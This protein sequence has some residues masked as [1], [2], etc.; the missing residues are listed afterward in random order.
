MSCYFYFLCGSNTSRGISNRNSHC[1]FLQKRWN[2]NDCYQPLENMHVSAPPMFF[3]SPSWVFRN[4]QGLLTN[5][6]C[7]PDVSMFWCYNIKLYF[8]LLTKIT[9][10]DNVLLC[11]N[12]IKHNCFI[13]GFTGILCLSG[14]KKKKKRNFSKGKINLI[15]RWCYSY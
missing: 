4:P 2:R 12:F 14:K 5:P 11:F 3:V 9:Y 7:R 10:H 13:S 15:I 6:L 1:S 8:S